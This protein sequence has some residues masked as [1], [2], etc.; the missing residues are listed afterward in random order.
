MRCV[1]VQVLVG[2][3]AEVGGCAR[4]NHALTHVVT[5]IS[6]LRIARRYHTLTYAGGNLG[7]LPGTVSPRR[8]W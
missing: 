3:T 6:R 1:S 2:L 7:R 5:R 4:P 8:P